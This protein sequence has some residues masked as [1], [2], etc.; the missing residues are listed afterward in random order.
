MSSLDQ[1]FSAFYTPSQK[2]TEDSQ[3]AFN[4]HTNSGKEK[5]CDP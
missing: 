3:K 2:R 1:L 5:E 4:S